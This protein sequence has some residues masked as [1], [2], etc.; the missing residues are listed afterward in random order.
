VINLD[1]KKQIGMI[2]ENIVKKIN[3]FGKRN[4]GR[5]KLK[6]TI[7]NLIKTIKITI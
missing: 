4:F 3:I 5:K 2:K 7:L 1:G 6:K